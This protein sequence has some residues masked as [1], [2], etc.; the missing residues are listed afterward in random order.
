MM[1][2]ET[3]FDHVVVALDPQTPAIEE[4]K[5]YSEVRDRYFKLGLIPLIYDREFNTKRALHLTKAF[6]DDIDRWNTTGSRKLDKEKYGRGLRALLSSQEP[7]ENQEM[8]QGGRHE[9]QEEISRCIDFF[10]G[11]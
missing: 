2:D 3:I 10:A 8:S 7:P 4:T 6:A 11:M 5:F 1:C 9:R